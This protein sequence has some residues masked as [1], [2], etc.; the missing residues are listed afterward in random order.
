MQVFEPDGFAANNPKFETWKVNPI[1]VLY[2]TDLVTKSGTWCQHLTWPATGQ[3]STMKIAARYWLN[4]A[5]NGSVYDSLYIYMYVCM[6]V[7]MYVV[8][9]YVCMYVCM[10]VC[11]YVCMFGCCSF[12]C[13][14]VLC[15]VVPRCNV[16][17]YDEPCSKPHPHRAQGYFTRI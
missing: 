3:S 13:T 7:C 12:C 17:W 11:M 2:A 6:Y 16:L 5:R 10:S 1:K 4:P 15:T 14:T 9:M 8:C